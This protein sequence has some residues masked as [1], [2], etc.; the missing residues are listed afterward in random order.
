MQCIVSKLKKYRF[1]RRRKVMG[2]KID[3]LSTPHFMVATLGK[4]LSKETKKPFY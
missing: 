1:C 2:P 3:S 4:T